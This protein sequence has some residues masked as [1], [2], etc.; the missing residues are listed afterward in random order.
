MT[1]LTDRYID[2]TLRGI[3]QAQRAELEPE[4]RALIADAT[5]QATEVDALTSLGDPSRLAASYA[6][7]P[8]HLIGP[9]LFLDYRRALLITL[10]S[11]V[12]LIFVAV[13]IGVLAS[14]GR[15]EEALWAA[16]NAALQVALHVA[17]WTTVL[18][19]IVERTPAMRGARNGAWQPR[20]LRELPSQR[21]DLAALIGGSSVAALIAAFLIVMQLASPVRT[22]AGEPIGLIVPTLWNSGALLLVLAFAIASVAFDV[23]GYYVGWGYIQALSNAALSVIFTSVV[24]V[25]AFSG[26]L[27]NPEFFATVGWPKGAGSNGVITW[28]IAV[29]IL[30]LGIANVGDGFGRAATAHGLTVSTPTKEQGK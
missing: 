27:L 2:A 28:I 7:R 6:D 24:L 10:T 23:A 30:L 8:L 22:E 5:E 15:F 19:A 16:F 20:H 4:L 11:A 9:A 18:F 25:L 17:V 1:S 13:G 29:F 26:N 3:P 12:P 14:G 21:V